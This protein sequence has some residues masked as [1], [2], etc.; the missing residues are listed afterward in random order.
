LSS[1]RSSH[2]PTFPPGVT[3]SARSSPEN[4]H[5]NAPPPWLGPL[6]PSPC[7]RSIPEESPGLQGLPGTVG[8]RPCRETAAAPPPVTAVRIGEEDGPASRWVREALRDA[9]RSASGSVQSSARG[10]SRWVRPT[11]RDARRGSIGRPTPFASRCAPKLL[12]DG[13]HTRF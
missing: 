7:Q 2:L 9:R 8:G 13:C 3:A 6:V 4:G 1:Q 12:Q 5:S 11:H 10:A